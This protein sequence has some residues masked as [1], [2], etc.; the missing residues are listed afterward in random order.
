MLHYS[1]TAIIMGCVEIV[2][3]YKIN[4]TVTL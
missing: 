4:L 2:E 3:L 1:E